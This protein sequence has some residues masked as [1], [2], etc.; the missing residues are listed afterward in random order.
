MRNCTMVTAAGVAR[1]R[2][3]SKLDM[4]GCAPAAI[5]A[6]RAAGL[7]VFLGPPAAAP[8]SPDSPPRPFP[9]SPL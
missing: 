7:P 2:V 1:L 6:A 8:A 3:A 4:L 5:T 9:Q